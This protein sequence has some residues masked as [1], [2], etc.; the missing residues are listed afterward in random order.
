MKTC[1]KWLNRALSAAGSAAESPSRAES[2][3]GSAAPSAAETPR[4]RRNSCMFGGTFGGRKSQTETKVSFRGQLR[5]PKGLP[6]QPCSAAE[7]AFGCPN[8]FL[9]KGRNLAPFAHFASKPS[10]HAYFSTKACI[11]V[12]RGLKHAHT[13][14][15]TLQT[16]SNNTHCSKHQYIPITQHMS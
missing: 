5:Q 16:Y 13:P 11:Q 15:T 2:Q 6:P 9:Q 4:Q 3:A 8:W 1:K 10:K 7:S 14:S 12:P